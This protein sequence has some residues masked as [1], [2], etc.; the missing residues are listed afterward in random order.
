MDPLSLQHLMIIGKD[1][2]IAIPFI[3]GFKLNPNPL[4]VIGVE[5]GARYTLTDNL[6][7]SNPENEFADVPTYKFGNISNNDCIFL[8]V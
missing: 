1:Q 4:F 3:L 7:G 2:K 5:M 8:Q 6:D